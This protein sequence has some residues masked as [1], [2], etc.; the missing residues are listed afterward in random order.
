MTE[1]ESPGIDNKQTNKQT[2]TKTANDRV[3]DQHDLKCDEITSILVHNCILILIALNS[4]YTIM[5]DSYDNVLV[6]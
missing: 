6:T 2:T 3:L 1:I 4:A 5:F